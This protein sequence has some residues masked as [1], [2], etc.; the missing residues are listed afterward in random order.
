MHLNNSIHTTP[1]AITNNVTITNPSE[2]SNTFKNYFA[3]VF[4]D[5]Q[6]SIRFSKKRYCDYLPL[7]NI[8][9]NYLFK[10]NSRNTRI[11]CEISSKLTIKLTSTDSN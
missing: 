11:R 5:M 9:G 7:L 1:S 6:Y 4:I 10:V 8:V 3:K 2:T